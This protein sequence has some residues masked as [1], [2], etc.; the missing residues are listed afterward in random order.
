M[1]LTRAQ[2]IAIIKAKRQPRIIQIL[3]E[4]YGVSEE[5]IR[6]VRYRCRW[7]TKERRKGPRQVHVIDKNTSPRDE[8]V[9]RN[10]LVDFFTK[11]Y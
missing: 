10:D 7:M 9:A 8:V 2:S 3:A 1:S 4:R 6:F 5:F 11:R